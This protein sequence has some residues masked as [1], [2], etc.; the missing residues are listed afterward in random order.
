[1]LRF[2][3]LLAVLPFLIVGV[4]GCGDSEPAAKPK[5]LKGGLKEGEGKTVDKSKAVAD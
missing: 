2:L 4:S 5:I 1:M 3:L